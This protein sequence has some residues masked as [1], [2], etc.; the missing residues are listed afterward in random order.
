MNPC[1]PSAPARPPRP[2]RRRRCTRVL[3]AQLHAAST[4]VG[5][6]ADPVR[7][8]HEAPPTRAQL[9]AQP[10]IDGGLIG[11]ASLKA[12]TSLR[13]LPRRLADRAAA[14][15]SNL[16]ARNEC[17]L[18]IVLAVQML[19]ALVHDRPDP[20]PARQGRRHG[21]GLRQRF[22][23]QPVRCQRQR[24]LPVAHHRCARPACSSHAR[25]LLAYFGT[26]ADRRRGLR[27]ACS[28]APPCRP[29][30]PAG[31]CRLPGAADR[32]AGSGSGRRPRPASAPA[33]PC[34]AGAPARSAG[35]GPDP[36]AMSSKLLLQRSVPC[37]NR[38]DFRVN[39]KGCS[40]SQ[41]PAGS[42]CH[43]DSKNRGR[44]EIGR[45]AILRG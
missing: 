33:V 21:C 35:G 3:R 12:P 15:L 31:R 17:M 34:R 32:P 13:S 10:D 36:D 42:S 41:N 19:S 2:S 23:G 44:G 20:G 27:A 45:H 26:C 8:Q 29:P 14:T 7:R 6:D 11:G 9:L 37:R 1:G 22:V 28:S 39:S 16:G 30:W 5:R 18:T 43:P 4:Q 24:Q 25:W 38:S 40:E